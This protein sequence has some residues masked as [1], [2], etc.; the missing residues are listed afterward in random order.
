MRSRKILVI[1]AEQNFEGKT[2]SME[3]LVKHAGLES[4]QGVNKKGHVGCKGCGH[5]LRE[6][7]GRAINRNAHKKKAAKWYNS[8]SQKQNKRLNE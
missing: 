2:E 3:G 8:Q 1:E 6:S 7:R 4:L 5:A